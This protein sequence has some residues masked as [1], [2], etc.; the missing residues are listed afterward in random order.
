VRTTWHTD[1]DAPRSTCSHCGSPNW[2]DH[3]VPA[4]PSK[5]ADAGRPAFSTDDAVAGRFSATLVL[6]Q[7]PVGLT[8]PKTWNSHSEYPYGV[9]R[10]VPYMRT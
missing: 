3:R 8:V 1:V 6:P 2:L 5:A 10:V 4:L 9:A 7:V